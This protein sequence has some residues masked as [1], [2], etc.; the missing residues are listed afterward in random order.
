MGTAA[1]RAEAILESHG[2][3]IRFPPKLDVAASSTQG[4]VR[5]WPNHLVFQSVTLLERVL[6]HAKSQQ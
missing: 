3:H 5:V 1:Q 2:G 6:G 4:R